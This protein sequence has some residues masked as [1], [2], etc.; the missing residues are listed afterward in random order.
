MSK[1]DIILTIFKCCV[2][3]IY[4]IVLLPNLK[5]MYDKIDQIDK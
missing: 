1:Y 4:L 2:S 3:K 5:G